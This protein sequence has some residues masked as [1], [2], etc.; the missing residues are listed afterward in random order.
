[1]AIEAKVTLLNAIRDISADILTQKQAD[2]MLGLVADELGKYSVEMT[3]QD[4]SSDDCLDAYISAKSCE[5]K[6]PKTLFRYKYIISRFMKTINVRTRDITVYHLRKYLADEKARGMADGTVKG[7]REC[8]NAYFNWLFREGLIPKNPCVNL[9]QVKCKNVV[10]QAYADTEL[11]KIKRAC[12]CLRDLAI[13]CFLAATGCRIGEVTP[14]NIQDIDLKNRECKVLGKGNKER[15]VYFDSVTAMIL[16]E[17]LESR[18][19]GYEALFPGNA[20]RDRSDRMT[21]QGIRR[22]LEKVKVKAH[23]TN[24]VHPHKFRRTLATN[25]IHKGMPIQEVAAILG[26]SKLDTTMEY[27]VLNH[28]DIRHDYNKYFA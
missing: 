4:N 20:F 19:D 28:E 3:A 5:G 26:H 22:M 27:V 1:M 23:I 9:G 25:L 14:L 21:D 11:E 12:R 18:T 2:E 16:S 7:Y 6:S 15:I 24:K 17:Y 8:F 13:V 10:K